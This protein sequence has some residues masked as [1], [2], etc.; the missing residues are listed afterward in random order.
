M[1]NEP[2]IHTLLGA[3]N[4][5][6][7]NLD[8]YAFEEND[9]LNKVNL[10]MASSA[11]PGLF[12]PIKYN[13]NLYADGGTLSNELLQV[14]HNKRQFCTSLLKDAEHRAAPKQQ[15]HDVFIV[16]PPEE[17]PEYM[18]VFIKIAQKLIIEKQMNSED[19]IEILCTDKNF[20][21]WL[22]QKA[23]EIVNYVVKKVSGGKYSPFEDDV[24]LG[25]V[26]LKS[27]AEDVIKTAKKEEMHERHDDEARSSSTAGGW[28][29]H[30]AAGAVGGGHGH[31]LGLDE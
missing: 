14:E 20:V 1:P 9:D 23:K 5:Y 6:S 31:G 12:P 4:L 18:K 27:H 19:I 17:E 15:L 22:I 11:I 29:E 21:E 8:V 28:T 13:G 30:V 3:T 26:D 16:L 10:M 24:L 2:V 7:G 25:S